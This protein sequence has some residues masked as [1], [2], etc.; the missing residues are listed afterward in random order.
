M[1]RY[2]ADGDGRLGPEEL[3]ALLRDVAGS[4]LANP[5]VGS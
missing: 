2:D 5:Q 1:P 3:G 4:R